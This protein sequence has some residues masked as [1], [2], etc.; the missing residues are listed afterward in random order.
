MLVP[1]MRTE[2][3][4]HVRPFEKYI[5]AINTTEFIC[6]K[7]RTVWVMGYFFV[8]FPQVDISLYQ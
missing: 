5:C 1:K 6:E 7:I 4:V 8:V 2:N 3:W